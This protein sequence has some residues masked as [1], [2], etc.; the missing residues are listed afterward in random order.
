MLADNRILAIG[1]AWE[2]KSLTLGNTHI[3]KSTTDIAALR[4]AGVQ[5][6]ITRLA[7]NFRLLCWRTLAEQ[8]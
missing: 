4:S 1:N 2:E 3:L 7:R 6:D 8:V 5:T